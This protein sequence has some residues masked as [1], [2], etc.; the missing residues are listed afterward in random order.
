MLSS[1]WHLSL[2]EMVW[3]TCNHEPFT[4]SQ[5]QAEHQSS[6]QPQLSEEVS[7]PHILLFESL[8]TMLVPWVAILLSNLWGFLSLM[9]MK[10]SAGQVFSYITSVGGSAAYIAWA[11]IIFTHL[12]I[13]A[14]AKRQDIDV[15]SFPFRAFG[16]I[17]IYR[18]N[19]AV[20]IFLLLIQGF[21]VFESPFDWRNFIASYI[22]IPTFFLL[23]FGFKFYY[24]TEW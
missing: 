19:F 11:A 7:P 13:R 23:F 8:L 24:K 10:L 1:W 12:R 21:T 3:S 6:S 18:L 5:K 2:L 14:A 22:T 4:H 17:W 16:S 15:K 9:N 20:N